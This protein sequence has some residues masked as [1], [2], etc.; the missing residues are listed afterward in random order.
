MIQSFLNLPGILGLVLMDGRSQPYFCGLERGLNYQQR[1]AL[2]QGIQQV[3]STTPADFESFTFRFN[4][5]EAHI[6]K[7]TGD[8]ILLVLTDPVLSTAKY[9]QSIQDLLQSLPKSPHSIVADFRTMAEGSTLKGQS[10]WHPEPDGENKADLLAPSAAAAA[11][12]PP[13]PPA[14]PQWEDILAAVNSLSDETARY[15][16]KIVVA[17]TW[18]T[19]HKAAPSLVAFQVNRSGHL[20]LSDT[21][22]I[23]PD[24]AISSQ[25]LAAIQSWVNA[26]IARCGLVIRDYRAMVLATALSDEQRTMLQV[27]GS[28]D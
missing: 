24:S 21:A 20:T 26:F 15:L 10:Y 13:S 28:E 22:A 14:P 8:I 5:Q 11:P 25:D 3:V 9:R 23:S 16:G 12:P 4:Y 18:R 7:I 17:N 1:Q 6:H 19:T 2:I 27:N